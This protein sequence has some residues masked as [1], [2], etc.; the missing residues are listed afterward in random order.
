[1]DVETDYHLPL[2]QL[3]P[4]WVGD[5]EFRVITSYVYDMII[6]TGSGATPIN[7]AGQSGPAGGFSGSY[8]ASPKLQSNTFLTYSLGDFT[9]TLQWRYVG[10]GRYLTFDGI[11]AVYTCTT[12]TCLPGSINDNHVESASYF[13]LAAT[14]KIL[15]SLQLFARVDNVLNKSPPIAPSTGLATNPALFDTLGTTYKVGVRFQY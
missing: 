5:L 13:N 4:N 12:A 10:S 14:Y 7:Y 3:V 8:N 9:G 15:K 6:D 2:T 1:V 11:N